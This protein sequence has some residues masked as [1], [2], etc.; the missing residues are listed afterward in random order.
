MKFK[1]RTKNSWKWSVTWW[2]FAIRPLGFISW[3]QALKRLADMRTWDCC[4][5][6][7]THP[8][9][10]PEP[11]E[12]EP[13]GQYCA[14]EADQRVVITPQILMHCEVQERLWVQVARQGGQP[15]REE[16]GRV[17]QHGR[18]T[19]KHKPLFTASHSSASALSGSLKL[20][21]IKYFKFDSSSSFS[22]SFFFGGCDA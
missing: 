7:A 14:R 18:H 13:V 2:I 22:S 5:L 16:H 4:A 19:L 3:K 10:E 12:R 11:G 6:I 21:A 15:Q 8:V 20:G 9:H 1:L 17:V